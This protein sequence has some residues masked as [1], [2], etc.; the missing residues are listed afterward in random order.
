MNVSILRDF[1][2]SLHGW[3]ASS[4]KLRK[5][6]YGMMEWMSPRLERTGRDTGNCDLSRLGSWQ[7]LDSAGRCLSWEMMGLNAGLEQEGKNTV[8]PCPMQ[9]KFWCINKRPVLH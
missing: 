4:A 7:V 2:K 3:A 6:P 5:P 8:I 9:A 1:T